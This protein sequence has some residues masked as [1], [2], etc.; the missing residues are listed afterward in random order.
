M[1]VGRQLVSLTDTQILRRLE[2]RLTDHDRHVRANTAFVFAGLGD[3]RGFDVI[4][5]IL[6][7]LSPRP[8]GQGIPGGR[9]SLDP[10]IRADRYYAVHVLGGLADERAVDLL[11]PWLADSDVNYKVAW[12]LGEIRNTRAVKPLIEAL[13]NND[14]LVRISAIQALVKLRAKESLPHIRALLNDQAMPRAGDRVPVAATAKAAVLELE[15]ELSPR[16]SVQREALADYQG[17]YAYHGG[18]SIVLVAADTLLFA[19]IDEAKYPL[20]QSAATDF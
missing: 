20:R 2:R 3:P 12:A 5:G 15:Q 16:T 13:R 17:V 9:W 10:Q 19:V 8:E 18:T 11:L 4:V 1:E 14:A 7:D 6:N